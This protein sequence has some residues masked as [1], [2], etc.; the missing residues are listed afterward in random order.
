MDAE[1]TKEAITTVRWRYRSYHSSVH[2]LWCRRLLDSKVHQWKSETNRGQG[3]IYRGGDAWL[4]KWLHFWIGQG[5]NTSSSETH[6][7]NAIV[8]KSSS[9][10]ILYTISHNHGANSPKEILTIIVV[11][12]TVQRGQTSLCCFTGDFCC[13]MDRIFSW[14]TKKLGKLSFFSEE[15]DR[16]AIVIDSDSFQ[17]LHAVSQ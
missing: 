5:E 1:L 11:L 12:G 13:S 17:N 9:S 4:Q 2:T 3:P 8:I 6:G 10:Q 7:Q 16:N 14:N 15:T